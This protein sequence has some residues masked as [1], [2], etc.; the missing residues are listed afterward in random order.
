ML[1]P[2]FVAL[3]LFSFLAVLYTLLANGS[4]VL[5][6]IFLLGATVFLS[7]F[8][9]LLLYRA[10]FIVGKYVSIEGEINRTKDTYY[11]ALHQS[12]I[13]WSEG[14]NDY[15]PFTE[16]AFGVVFAE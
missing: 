1:N 2:V 4:R 6:S 10:G 15:E 8:L 3:P 12:S 5:A 11:D 7:L 16:Y 14:E 13:G 9:L